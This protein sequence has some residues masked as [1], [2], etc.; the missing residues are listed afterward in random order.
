MEAKPETRILF[1]CKTCNK[2]MLEADRMGKKYE[3]KCKTCKN[4]VV[5]GTEKAIC[6]YFQIKDSMLERMLSES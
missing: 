1:Y 5:F 4:D 2:A 6:D 3:Y